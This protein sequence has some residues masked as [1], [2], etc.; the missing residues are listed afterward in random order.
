MNLI[1]VIITTYNWPEALA[2]SLQS[3][4]AQVDH[5]FEI[6]VAD[7]GSSHATADMLKD[8]FFKG[9]V[10][11]KHIRHDDRG[12]RAGTIRN[13]AVANSIGDYLIF[14]DGDCIV[15]PDFISTHRNLARQGYFV[16]GN[17]VL[18]SKPFTQAVLNKPIALY[19]LSFRN[20]FLYRL[21]GKINRIAPLLRLPLGPLRTIKPRHWQKAMTCNLGIWKQDF[22]EVNGFDELFEGWGYEDSDLV[23]RLIHNGVKRKE[24]RFAVPVLHLWH[25]QNDQSQHD[26]NLRRLMERLQQNDFIRA[27]KGLSQYD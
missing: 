23:I 26:Q 15:F 10:P 20:F 21:A 8:R 24:G 9:P 17:R 13:K 11:L 18:L 19:E 27:E 14:I 4:F 2:A 22:I 6:L 12:F 1:S 16:P 7:D 3:L 5:H 25:R